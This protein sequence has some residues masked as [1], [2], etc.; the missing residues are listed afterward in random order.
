MG[1]GDV[2]EGGH[3]VKAEILRSRTGE[4]RKSGLIMGK[5]SAALFGE[6]VFLEAAVG[7]VREGEF[8]LV[9]QEEFSHE[10]VQIAAGLGLPKISGNLG[11][12]EG[13]AG[14]ESENLRGHGRLCP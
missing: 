3:E 4:E 10:V 9:G 5:P 14:E 7:F 13:F 8:D 6:P 12:G 11:F 2:V 1:D